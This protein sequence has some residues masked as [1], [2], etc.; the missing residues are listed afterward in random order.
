[1]ARTRRLSLAGA[2]LGAGLGLL[3]GVGVLAAVSVAGVARP[4]SS[5]PRLE[6]THLPPLLTAAGEPVLLRYDV[7]CV[8]ADEPTA[9]CDAGGT[10][11]ARSGVSGPFQALPLA[12]DP[13]ASDGRYSVRVPDALARSGFWYYAVFSDARTGA[14]ASLPV[15]APDALERSA[16][17]GRSA[18][19]VRLAAHVFGS[20]RAA[21]G[22]VASASWGDGSGEVGLEERGPDAT[23]IGASSFDVDSAGRVTVLDEAHRRLL[24]WTPGVAGPDVVP[25][26]VSGTIA[27]VAS[28]PDGATYVLDSGGHGSDSVVR[29]FDARGLQRGASDVGVQGE[30][31]RSGPDGPIVLEPQSARW[32]SADRP[33]AAGVGRPVG[34]GLRVVAYRPAAGEARVAT[35][36]GS[37]TVA[38]AWRIESS[39]PIGEVQL[40]EPL[41]GRLVVVLRVY[42]ETQAEFVALVLG[43]GGVERQFSVAAAEWAEAAPLGRFRLARGSLY[44]LGSTPGGMFVDRYDLGVS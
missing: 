28:G 19:A 3:V 39:T 25:V 11:Y 5:P 18:V 40:A 7:Y 17:M 8:G 35:V 21:D 36:T 12:V 41:G 16:P 27:D 29:A 43:G 26:Q 32:S 22:R 44:R 2:A 31:V 30:A 34:G 1:V 33:Q 4:R 23:P 6:A 10:V 38:R 37:G 14:S 20:T 9:P 15:G 42:D 13:A 24:R